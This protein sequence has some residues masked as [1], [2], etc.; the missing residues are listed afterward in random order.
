[1]FTD[2]G[3]LFFKVLT[4]STALIGLAACTTSG[5]GN[6]AAEQAQS[7]Q[8]E[9]QRQEDIARNL[10]GFCP[11]TTIREGT[12]SF[13]VF[14]DGVKATDPGSNG[15]IKFQS[16]ISEV[17]RECNY[18]G[19]NL[20]LRVGIKGR[21]INGPSGAT[22]TLNVPIRVAVATTGK[23]VLYSVLHQVPV[24]IPE[25]GSNAAFSYIDEQINIPAPDKANLI[26][27]VGFDE[28]PPES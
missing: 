15:K 16:T 11:K 14:D 4:T 19:N 10:R 18:Q 22:G 20:N 8:A 21:V 2:G 25:G 6:S 13:R 23:D 24:T 26:V 12:E 7:Q 9:A 17:A 5:A 27:F 3:N 28:G 1:M